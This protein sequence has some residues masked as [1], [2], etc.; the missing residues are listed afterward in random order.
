VCCDHVVVITVGH[1]I[2]RVSGFC[3]RTW[4][5]GRRAGRGAGRPGDAF[6]VSHARRLRQIERF[7][8]LLGGAVLLLAVGNALWA[9]S[10]FAAEIGSGYQPSPQA[11]LLVEDPVFVVVVST[12]AVAIPLVV[13]TSAVFSG[14]V[15]KAQTTR[16][17]CRCSSCP[18]TTSMAAW[19]QWLA[20][21][22]RLSPKRCRGSRSTRPGSVAAI[23]ITACTSLGRKQ[24]TFTMSML[25]MS[26]SGRSGRFGRRG[27]T[28][29]LVAGP[30]DPW[31]GQRGLLIR[32]SWPSE[33]DAPPS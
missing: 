7:A 11:H 16:A 8:A 14:G 25:S 6:Y 4:R 24:V 27:P 26:G 33:P 10:A 22:H 12:M 23:T 18:R 1:V 3:C 2:L 29:G 15:P 30:I 21:R 5:C 31:R 20:I 32:F 13:L 17:C 9:A 28:P 19:V